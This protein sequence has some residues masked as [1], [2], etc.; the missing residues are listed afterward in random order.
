MKIK[1]RALDEDQA[2]EM[3]RQRLED[4]IKERKKYEGRW[5][6]NESLL[7]NGGRGLLSPTASYDSRGEA[8]ILTGNDDGPSKYI[9]VPQVMR[10][11]RILHSQLSA[12][13]PSAIASPLSTEKKDVDTATVANHLIQYGI[14]EY[15]GQERVDMLTLSTQVYG[16]GFTKIIYDGSKGR[17]LSFNESTMEAEM[18]GDTSIV[19][20]SIW[21]IYLDSTATTWKNVRYFFEEERMPLQLALAIHPDKEDELRNS[22]VKVGKDGVDGVVTGSLETARMFETEETEIVSVFHY[23]EKGDPTNGMAGRY[24]TCLRDGTLLSPLSKSPIPKAKLPLIILTDIDVPGQVYGRT[25]VDYAVEMSKII[26][27]MDTMIADNIELH[28]NLHLVVFDGSGVNDS[29]LENSPVSVIRVNGAAN[30]TPKHLSPP[31]L[32]GDI[33]RLRE[34]KVAEIDA[35]M[36]VNEALQGQI[37]RELSGFAVTTAINAANM[38]RRRLYNKYTAAVGELW[39]Q[40]L[41]ICQQ[42]WK[43]SRKIRVVGSE[44]KMLVKHYKGTD[45][46]GGYAIRTTYGQFFS[47]DPNQRREELLQSMPVLEKA[48]VNPKEIARQ[49]KLT[50]IDSIFDAMDVAKKRQY[51]IFDEIIESY[52]RETGEVK[53]IPAG[54]MKKAYHAE[55]AE[56]GYQYTMQRQ[57]LELPKAVRDAIYQHI[58]EREKLAAEAQQPAPEEVQAAPGGMPGVGPGLA[59]T[60][61]EGAMPDLGEVL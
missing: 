59:P 46:E 49:L 40:F 16:T 42:D 52:D 18:E 57:F 4:S 38:A 17:L 51:E 2:K 1:V 44:D 35:I 37:P 22:L 9:H 8:G 21:R 41:D 20:V 45:L 48:G 15:D 25:P 14:D 29:D 32:T 10:N 12:N 34:S 47:L 3:L 33:Y 23:Y 28:G 19:D 50:E 53:N 55:M 27:D 7:Y 11:I 26:D 61:A 43:E 24:T 60:P 30:E 58:D 5:K 6:E 39:Q 31:P 13:P 54:N 56:A 36:G